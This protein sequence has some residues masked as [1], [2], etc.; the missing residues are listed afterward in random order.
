MRLTRVYVRFFKSFNFDYERRAKDGAM[1]YEWEQLPEGWYPHVRLDVDPHVTAVVGAN[2]SG[3]SHLL[4]AIECV[5]GVRPVTRSDFCRYSQLYSVETHEVR[6]PDVGAVF[7]VTTDAEREA[8]AELGVAIQPDETFLFMRPGSGHPFIVC[9]GSTTEIEDPDDLEALEAILPRVL[10][11]STSVAI[12]DSVPIAALWGGPLR[13]LADRRLRSQF[14]DAAEEAEPGTDEATWSKISAKLLTFVRQPALPTETEEARRAKAE[15]ALARQLLVDVARIDKGVFK[16]LQKAIANGNEGEVSGLEGKINQSLARHLNFAR[17]WSQDSDF[18]LRVTVRERELV[19]TIRDRTGTQYSFGERSRGLTHFLAY[20]VQ[21]RAHR[22]AEGRT[23][24]LLMDE[25][26]AYLSNSGQQDLLRVLENFALPDDASR[27]D[28]V[29]YVTHSPFLIN[30]NA[31]SRLRVL[32][33]GSQEEGT[34]VVKD[35]ARTHYEPLR[36]S[37]GTYVAETAFI[38]GRNLIVEGTADQV[39]LAGMSN[40]LRARGVNAA[41]LLDLNEVTIV[42]AGSAD[43]VPYIAYLARGRDPIKPPCV[44]L[45]DGDDDGRRAIEKLKKSEA[46]RKPVLDE[47]FIVRLDQWAEASRQTAGGGADSNAGH[48]VASTAASG[49]VTEIEDLIP[50]RIAILAARAYA[51]RLLGVK[52][53]DADQLKEQDLKD[54]L[55]ASGKPLWDALRDLVADRLGERIDKVGFAREVVAYLNSLPRTGG[56]PNGVPALETNFTCLLNHLGDLLDQAATDEA[57]RRRAK[58]MGRIVRGFLDDYQTGAPRSIADGRLREIEAS[59]DNS[60]AHDTFKLGIAR[61]RRD[62]ALRTDPMQPI[63][64]FPSFRQRLEDLTL[65]ERL[66]SQESDADSDGPEY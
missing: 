5:M 38:G 23:E 35:V 51:T 9:N 47:R 61:L 32:D 59:L 13:S 25:P 37:L 50:A 66:E 42:P 45:L 8:M 24:I 55:D 40:A 14:L 65:R 43:S 11:F 57:D 4:D 52:E 54:R 39:L 58:R 29:L 60:V 63:D 22:P 26:D 21:L 44:A 6:L 34:R 28:Q 2:E 7:A 1:R 18:Q 53:E 33:K 46:N 49:V 10:R 56:R 12:P 36:S 31:A 3:K 16:G 48:E 17:W 41:R 64:D 27:A 19:F 62:F 15:T 20:F 30:K